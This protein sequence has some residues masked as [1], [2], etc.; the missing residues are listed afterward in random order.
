MSYRLIEIAE[1]LEAELVSA[2]SVPG[3]DDIPISGIADPES[4]MFDQI[5]FVSSTKYIS[6]AQNSKAAALI[7]SADL[8]DS[9]QIPLLVVKN[10]YLAYAQLSAKFAEPRP[11]AEVHPSSFVAETAQ[12]GEGVYIGAN[13]VV[14]DN[15]VIADN[16]VISACSV[17][18]ARARIGSGTMLY[19]NVSIYHDVVIG[20]D[21]V[22]HSGAVI[23][24]DGFGFAPTKNGYVKI[25]QLGSVIVGDDV[26][27]GSNT[28][29][30]RGALGDTRI[31]SGAK[32]DNLVHV[33]HNCEIGSHTAI[34]G[35]VGM[36]GSTKIG[37]RCSF[38]GQVGIAGHLEI[39]DDVHALGQSRIT[40]SINKPGIFA[41]GTGTTEA[42]TWR[43]NAA[44][45]NQL[46]ELY[47]R[48]N[49]LEKLL[50][51]KK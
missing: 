5:S 3:L 12:I 9:F 21:C 29:I 4:A 17:I 13:A 15:V 7:V 11:V 40:K 44:R 35:Q 42:K 2:S 45:F 32:I 19:P 20:K 25:H 34:A 33:A 41:S 22:I 36:A 43:K 30:D 23:G 48:I 51:K 49:E 31:H 37:Q 38:G 14:Q 50:E 47:R 46:D 28:S 1:Y 39:G 24:S 8:V 26:E 10:P 27:I 16:A 6:A 18:G